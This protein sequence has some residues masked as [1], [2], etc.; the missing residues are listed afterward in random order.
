MLRISADLVGAKKGD[1]I[2]F[3]ILILALPALERTL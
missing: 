3:S 2:P 1:A